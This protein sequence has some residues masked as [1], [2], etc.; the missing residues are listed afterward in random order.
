MTIEIHD[1]AATADTIVPLDGLNPRPRLRRMGSTFRYALWRRP[2]QLDDASR[3]WIYRTLVTV[4]TRAFGADMTPYWRDRR[5]GG[6]L[7]NISR[8]ALLVDR[9]G[10]MVGWTGFH[11]RPF[12]GS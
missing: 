9:D 4:S 8:F 2:A 3:D 12:G 5:A 7:D 11:L 6:Y 10:R 1:P